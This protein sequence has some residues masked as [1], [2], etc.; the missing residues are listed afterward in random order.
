MYFGMR[1]IVLYKS[2]NVKR[3]NDAGTVFN[4]GG[5]GNGGEGGKKGYIYSSSCDCLV[6]CIL[7]VNE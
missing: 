7:L 5:M 6:Q 3:V 1:G 4:T 2:R